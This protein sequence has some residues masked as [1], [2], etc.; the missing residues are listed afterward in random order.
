MNHTALHRTARNAQPSAAFSGDVAEELR[1]YDEHLRDVRGLAT[2]TRRQRTLTVGRLLQRK[3]ADRPIDIA[4]LR[5]E[6]IRRFLADQLDARPMHHSWHR[7]CVAT[8][9]TGP[10]AAIRLAD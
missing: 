2:G 7:R 9:V 5:P 3:F 10:P 1:R 6:D 4:R 8:S